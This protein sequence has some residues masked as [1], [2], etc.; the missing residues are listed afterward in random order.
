MSRERR[1]HSVIFVLP[2][3]A[4]MPQCLAYGCRIRRG[5]LPEGVSFHRFPRDVELCTVWALRCGTDVGSIKKF[6][7]EEIQ[8]K[9]PRHFLCSNHFESDMFELDYRHELMPDAMKPR[10]L[11]R[12]LTKSAVPTIFNLSSS[13]CSKSSKRKRSLQQVEEKD[14][15]KLISELLMMLSQ[16]QNRTST[17][18]NT[19]GMIMVDMG[20]LFEEIIVDTL[21]RCA[22][23]MSYIGPLRNMACQ[24]EKMKNG[25]SIGTQTDSLLLPFPVLKLRAAM[26]SDAATQFPVVGS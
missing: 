4:K 18:D 23:D 13:K 1:Q 21:D 24:T 15:Q 22:T 11:M 26:K 2:A 17:E 6:V 19:S 3:S 9:A 14:Q 20:Q 25:C 8:R 12:R 16:T 5:S 7:C 10:R